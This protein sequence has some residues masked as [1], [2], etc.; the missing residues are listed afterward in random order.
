MINISVKFHNLHNNELERISTLYVLNCLSAPWKKKCSIFER[1]GVK[2]DSLCDM[3]NA[4]VHEIGRLNES[5]KT[6]LR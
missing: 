1:N 4:P 3:I 2:F 6:E 5:R